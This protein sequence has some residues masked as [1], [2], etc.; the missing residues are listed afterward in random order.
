ML[1]YQGS[2]H[3]LRPRVCKDRHTGKRITVVVN[4]HTHSD[5][6]WAAE[7]HCGLVN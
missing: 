1:H 4:P 2:P 5:A 3:S 6:V 7:D